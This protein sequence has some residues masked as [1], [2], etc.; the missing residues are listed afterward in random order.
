MGH[1]LARP[2][3]VRDCHHARHRLASGFGASGAPADRVLR[4]CHRLH[5]PRH[6]DLCLHGAERIAHPQHGPRCGCPRRPRRTSWT[7]SPNRS[8]RCSRGLRPGCC[9]GR[10]SSRR[11]APPMI[12]RRMAT[13][14]RL[15]ASVVALIGL[16]ALGGGL[17]GLLHLFIDASFGNDPL[18]ENGSGELA[19]SMAAAGIGAALWLWSWSRLQAR[20]ARA[21]LDEASSPVR[22]AYLLTRGGR[23][24]DREPRQPRVRAV[25]PVRSHP[26]RRVLR[27]PPLRDV[28]SAG[29]AGGGGGGGRLPRPGAARRP[30]PESRNGGRARRPRLRKVRHRRPGVCWC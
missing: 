6:H 24:R 30:G 20:H 19:F 7:R 18:R 3:V 23:Q 28:R 12:P 1:R 11:R 2:L 4:G 5:G 29:A 17:T 27:E 25:F 15:D 14:D 16:A 8:S 26:G 13:A 9:T 21:P 10:G 22:R